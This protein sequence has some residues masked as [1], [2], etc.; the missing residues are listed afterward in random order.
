M[1]GLGSDSGLCRH[2]S[3]EQRKDPLPT[4][5]AR[6]SD[7]RLGLWGEG[8]QGWMFLAVPTHLSLAGGG[9]GILG[10]CSVPGGAHG[11]PG[12]GEGS[13]KAR[14]PSSCSTLCSAHHSVRASLPTES[15]RDPVRP[16]GCL[17][18]QRPQWWETVV[19]QEQKANH[20]KGKTGR[21]RETK[22][23]RKGFAFNTHI[24]LLSLSQEMT[25]SSGAWCQTFAQSVDSGLR[26][27][28]KPSELNLNSALPVMGGAGRPLPTGVHGCT[29]S[30]VRFHPE[31]AAFTHTGHSA[32]SHLLKCWTRA[33]WPEE[34]RI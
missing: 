26:A 1:H 4:P 22:T 34:S 8:N 6:A 16:H 14:L 24:V 28:R 9:G 29:T 32:V 33:W 23:A 5:G 12:R 11:R 27:P 15:T 19:S 20:P 18:T 17:E 25:L 2:N 21:A 30:E 7:I 13:H 10:L 31:P 3:L